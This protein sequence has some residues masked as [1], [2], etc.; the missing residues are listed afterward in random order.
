MKRVFYP[1][2]IVVG[3]L[4]VAGVAWSFH[5][6]KPASGTYVDPDHRFSFRVPDGVT[7]SDYFNGLDQPETVIAKD[8]NG[9]V[10]IAIMP[11]SRAGTLTKEGLLRDFLLRPEVS[12]TSVGGV[13]AINFK[14]TT[15]APNVWI[16]HDGYLYQIVDWGTDA[17]LLP[18][19]EATW[20]F[21]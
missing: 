2:G 9:T 12:T 11:W 1:A 6:A 15:D 4:V 3:L 21:F 8:G 14:D 20:K 17:T 16:V 7:V 18:A 5:A 13:P 19:I 10:Q